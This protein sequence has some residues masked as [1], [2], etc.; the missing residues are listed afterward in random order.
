MFIP[1]LSPLPLSVGFHPVPKTVNVQKRKKNVFFLLKE[2][3]IPLYVRYAQGG[4]LTLLNKGIIIFLTQTLWVLEPAYSSTSRVCQQ[5]T[6]FSEDSH[7][8]PA[9]HFNTHFV[10]KASFSVIPVPP[11]SFIPSFAFLIPLSLCLPSLSQS[12]L[13]QP[14]I[15]HL[16]QAFN[17]HL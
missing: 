6:C 14:T 15:T 7:S 17:L 5:E 13:P 4:Y 9:S 8:P 12:Q 1:S 10:I 16:S 2:N 11:P 3:Q